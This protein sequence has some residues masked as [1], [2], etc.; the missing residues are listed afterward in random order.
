MA[1]FGI[2]GGAG[3]AGGLPAGGEA[4]QYLAKASGAGGDAEWVDPP[5]GTARALTEAEFDEA[6]KF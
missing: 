3:G 1:L 6:F 2:G 4:G 5:T